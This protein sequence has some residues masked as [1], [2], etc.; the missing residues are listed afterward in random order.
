MC[1]SHNKMCVPHYKL[2][3]PHY[4]ICGLPTTKNVS[5]ITKYVCPTLQNVC[6]PLK[7]VCPPLQNMSPTTNYVCPPLQNVCVPHYKMCV[8]PT[9]KCVR[10]P[11]QNLCP[12]LKNMCVPHN[13]IC[14]PLQNKK[15][16][17][18]ICA[19]F[20]E[21]VNFTFFVLFS[22][23]ITILS[24]ITHH[25]QNYFRFHQILCSFTTTT[26]HVLAYSAILSTSPFLSFSLL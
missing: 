23:L 7:C 16:K 22:I 21:W 2:C 24:P 25:V 11:L 17:R 5:L 26:K 12:P 18:S 19:Y 15:M 10:P 4:K 6:P 8:S 9:T 3:V 13:K 1:V 14:P 20:R